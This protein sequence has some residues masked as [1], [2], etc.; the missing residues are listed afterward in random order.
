[1]AFRATSYG[2]SVAKIL[3]MDGDGLRPMPLAPAGVSCP[4]AVA[5]LKGRKSRDMFPD[6]RVPDGAM[7][8]LYLYFSALDTAHS[9]AQDLETRDGSF[10]HGIMHRQEPDESNAAYWFRRVGNH[11]IFTALHKHA[12]A[13]GFN[14]G[15][16]W[17]PFQF[18]DFCESARRKPG[19]ADEDL[20]MR[21]QLVEWQLLFDHCACPGNGKAG[22]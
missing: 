13:L 9:I 19:S 18:I 21:V 1:M 4:A 14:T 22:K 5:A 7:A 11:A 10:W 12:A 6:S 16:E 15:V 17:N 2:P 20:A 3:G 8:G